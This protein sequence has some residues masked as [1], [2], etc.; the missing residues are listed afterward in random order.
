MSRTYVISYGVLEDGAQAYRLVLFRD[1]VSHLVR[2]DG[3]M[4]LM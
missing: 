2:C 3:P 4:E 1:L